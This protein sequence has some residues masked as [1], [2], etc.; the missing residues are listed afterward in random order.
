MELVKQKTRPKR[1]LR[2]PAVRAR[3]GEAATATIYGWMERG[4][5]PRPIRIGPRMVAWDEDDLDAH[6]ARLRSNMSLAMSPVRQSNAGQTGGEAVPNSQG[7]DR[8]QDR[9]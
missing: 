9:R 5:F 8:C 2:L 6:D 7:G 4:L 3:Y 1:Y